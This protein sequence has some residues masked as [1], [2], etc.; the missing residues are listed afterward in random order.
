MAVTNIP[1]SRRDIYAVIVRDEEGGVADLISIAKKHAASHPHLYIIESEKDREKIGSILGRKLPEHEGF[2]PSLVLTNPD[3]KRMVSAW[4]DSGQHFRII[5]DKL[6]ASDKAKKPT[7]DISENNGISLNLLTHVFRAIRENDPKI[8]I[9]AIK[10]DVELNETARQ[11]ERLKNA[12]GFTGSIFEVARQAAEWAENFEEFRQYLLPDMLD[13]SDRDRTR[14]GRA[15]M[16]IEGYLEESL[17]DEKVTIYRA[18]PAGE[19]IGVGDWVTLNKAYADE[20]AERYLS[21]EGGVVESIVVSGIDVHSYDG[22]PNEFVY[23]P[24]DCFGPDVSSMA[25][26]WAACGQSHKPESY[27]SIQAKIDKALCDAGLKEP[28]KL[29]QA[30]SY[31]PSPF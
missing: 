4:D 21:D 16:A 10:R 23:A 22:D 17:P 24:L 6:V 18:L 12:P 31:S 11:Q 27:P 26:L 14:L 8:K 7:D 29:N 2:K 19:V 20:H 25:D 3:H 30:K 15:A 1:E 5:G 13:T 28:K 9:E